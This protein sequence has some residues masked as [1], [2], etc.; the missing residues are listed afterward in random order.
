MGL[1]KSIFFGPI[2]IQIQTERKPMVMECRREFR[3]HAC[4]ICRGRVGIKFALHSQNSCS[5]HNKPNRPINSKLHIQNVV[6]V[7]KSS[8][9]T[10]DKSCFLSNFLIWRVVQRFDVEPLSGIVVSLKHTYIVSNRRDINSST[11]LIGD[12]RGKVRRKAVRGL[13]NRNSFLKT[14]AQHSKTVLSNIKKCFCIPSVCLFHVRNK[15][16]GQRSLIKHLSSFLS[17]GLKRSKR[18]VVPCARIRANMKLPT[19]PFNL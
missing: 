9:C 12:I 7:S 6:I 2:N 10:D 19:I 14:V 3:G 8:N 18:K 4:P 5:S 17:S 11:L 13:G 16:F 15:H 1:H